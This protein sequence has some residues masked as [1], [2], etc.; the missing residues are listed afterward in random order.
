VSP[1][2]AVVVN[3]TKVQDLGECRDWIGTE[4]AAA[5]WEPPLWSL[6]TALVVR[7]P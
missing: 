7:V 5:G 3:P 2:A 1:R 4:M 6:T